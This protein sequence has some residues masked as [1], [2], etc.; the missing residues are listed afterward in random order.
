MTFL[1]TYIPP[2]RLSCPIWTFREVSLYPSWPPCFLQTIRPNKNQWFG[3]LFGDRKKS[4]YWVSFI[5]RVSGI[6]PQLLR[7]CRLISTTRV[8]FV[9]SNVSSILFKTQI[10]SLYAPCSWRSHKKLLLVA[11]IERIHS[12]C[13]C[14]GCR[15]AAEIKLV[16]TIAISQFN[17]TLEV[18]REWIRC[19]PFP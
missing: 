11:C 6:S 9:R 1:Y 17:D 13:K 12:S 18:H 2:I 10:E 19:V 14:P 3:N 8:F 16:G 15:K 7:T 5:R 4:E